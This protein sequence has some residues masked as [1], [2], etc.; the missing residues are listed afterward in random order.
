[1][2]EFIKY[3][4]SFSTFMLL[5][6]ALLFVLLALKTKR[7]THR[8]LAVYLVFISF[9]QYYSTWLAFNGIYNLYLTHYYFVLQMLIL[10]YFYYQ[11]CNV[12]FQKNAIKYSVLVCL[13]I[14]AVQYAVRPELYF[15]LNKLEIFL[16]SYLLIIFA[17]FHFYNLLNSKKIFLYFNIGL[18]VYLFG[19]TLL[20][21]VGNLSVL[22]DLGGIPRRINIMIYLVFQL[23]IFIELIQIFRT[24]NPET[25]TKPIASHGT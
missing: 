1:M 19:S 8:I 24:K 14:L 5:L 9:I 7:K 17:L 22:I 18:F 6:N 11:I 20:F 16:C 13:T 25:K 4:V 3:A 15:I 23:C 2:I 21:L 12:Q 10:A